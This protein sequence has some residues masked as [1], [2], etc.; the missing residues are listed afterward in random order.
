MSELL[1]LKPGMRVLEIGTGSG[2][3][4]AILANLGCTVF[5]IE[6]LRDLYRNTSS[7]L[8]NLGF[9][10]IYTHFGDGTLGLPSAAPFDRI[11][12]TACGPKIP[13]PL[14]EQLDENGILLIPVGSYTRQRLKRLRKTRGQLSLEDFDSVIFV[15][16]VGLHGK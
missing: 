11:I 7:L 16:L 5:T 4:A 3:Q 12:V 14:I 1:H 15:D 9:R 2:Y 6:Y 13:K 8:R 10:A